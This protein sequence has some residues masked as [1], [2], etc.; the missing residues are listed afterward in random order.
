MDH[1]KIEPNICIVIALGASSANRPYEGLDHKIQ[2]SIKRI[3]RII[4][5]RAGKVNTQIGENRVFVRVFKVI[6]G[7]Y[8]NMITWRILPV[9]QVVKRHK[10]ENL[11]TPSIIRTGKSTA[12]YLSFYP[13]GQLRENKLVGFSQV[14]LKF[15]GV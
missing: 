10:S 2:R 12:P 14:F 11:H 3:A 5:C 9:L 1:D 13:G 6:T 4:S 15:H 8:E 7:D